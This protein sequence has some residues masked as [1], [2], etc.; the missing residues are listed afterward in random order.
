MRY[1]D[2]KNRKITVTPLGESSVKVNL[3]QEEMHEL[4]IEFGF[5]KKSSSNQKYGRAWKRIRDKYAKEHPVC[6]ICGAPTEEIHHII[7][8][9]LIGA[10]HSRDNLLA[11]CHECHAA[12][13]N[14][15]IGIAEIIKR[16]SGDL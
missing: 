4:L 8:V 6:E 16:K 15:K 14:N 12:I 9:D 7:A 2:N 3:S 10:N 11:V 5:H 13:H 1:I